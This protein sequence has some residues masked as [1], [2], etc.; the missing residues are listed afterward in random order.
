MAKLDLRHTLSAGRSAGQTL[1]KRPLPP[2]PLIGKFQVFF[3]GGRYY[4]GVC[5]KAYARADYAWLCVSNCTKRELPRFRVVTEV[6]NESSAYVC[7]FCRRHWLNRLD[8]Q[9]CV[10]SCKEKIVARIP[11][12]SLQSTL[13]DGEGDL[14]EKLRSHELGPQLSQSEQA[15]F[16]RKSA[17]AGAVAIEAGTVIDGI[18]LPVAIPAAVNLDNFDFADMDDTGGDDDC[19]DLDV[20][21]EWARRGLSSGEEEP[22]APVA[23]QKSGSSVN[24]LLS[25]MRAAPTASAPPPKKE[26]ATPAAVAPSEPPPSE[27]PPSPAPESELEDYMKYKRKP[28]Q[29]PFSRDGAR[30]VCNACN[31]K[32][33]TRSEV[34]RCFER[35]PIDESAPSGDKA[36]K[37]KV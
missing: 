15:H 26:V 35:H 27:P 20:R 25:E 19:G 32:F 4:C 6:V 21:E 10:E 29:K 23:Q 16:H 31:N 34:E 9:L 13:W 5:S 7:P 8:A 37:V 33:F 28:G 24:D 22:S 36:G 14:G 17:R 1:K 18:V 3:H 30:Y 2:V 11:G 12:E